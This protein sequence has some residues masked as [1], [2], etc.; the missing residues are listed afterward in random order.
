MKTLRAS[1]VF[2]FLLAC[3][4]AFGGTE[5]P[6]AELPATEL[7]PRSFELAVESAY[8]FGAI[9]PPADYQIGAEFMTARIRWGVVRGDTW[10]RD[11]IRI[12]VIISSTFGLRINGIGRRQQ[13]FDAGH[14][15]VGLADA[16]LFENHLLS[17][18]EIP[19]I[20]V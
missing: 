4:Q 8:L 20:A 1:V 11:G 12:F 10:L 6:S 5:R 14:I 19:E 13:V 3:L 16:N 2:A 15:Q 9:N 7:N 17:A 18:D